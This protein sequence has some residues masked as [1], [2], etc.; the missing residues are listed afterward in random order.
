MKDTD[1]AIVALDAPRRA[2]PANYPT[3]LVARMGDRE[4]R[5]LGDFFGLSTFGVNL[6]RLGPGAATAFLHAHS[7]QDEFVYVLQGTPTLRTERGEAVLSPGMC[8]GFPAGGPAHHLV[9]ETR[10]DILILEIGDR[11]ANDHVRYPTE[12]LLSVTAEGGVRRFTRKDGSAF[13]EA[14]KGR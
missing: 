1:L 3:E 6:T 10:A 9:N 14:E 5:P 7:R 13:G 2:A 8:A 4:K 11:G 12:D